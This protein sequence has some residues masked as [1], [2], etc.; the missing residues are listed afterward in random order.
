MQLIIIGAGGHGKVVLDIL[1]AGGQHEP[2]GFVDSFANRAGTTYCGLPI[3]GP[4]NVLP[5][6]RQQNIRG[7]IVAI[8]DCRARQRYATLLREQGFELVNAIHPTASISPT[9]VLG[10]NIVIAALVAVC[11]DAKIGDSAILNTSCVVDHECEV[12]EAVHICPGAH[13]A[14]RVRVGAGAW[15]GLGSN[16]IQCM[17]IGEHA[18][19]GAGAVVIHDV[20]ANATVV[21]VPARVVKT[22][23]PAADPELATTTDLMQYP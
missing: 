9:A 1:R 10:K 16:V 7:A 17:S 14:G 13:L 4:A 8:G 11:A 19:V 22:V 12:G 15:V 23:L 5:K 3:F 2:V 6:L 20:P 21:G 18:T